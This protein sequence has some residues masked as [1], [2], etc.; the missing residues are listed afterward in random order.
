MGAA[1]ALRLGLPVSIN[2]DDP[3]LFGASIDSEYRLA[4]LAGEDRDHVLRHSRAFRS[5]GR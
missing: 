3:V 4:G 1:R 5:A 2:T